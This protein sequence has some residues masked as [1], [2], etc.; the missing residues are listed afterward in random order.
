LSLYFLEQGLTSRRV[1][2]KKGIIARS[3]D[4]ISLDAVET[5]QIE[6]SVF[7]RL[8]GYAS[9]HITGRGDYHMVFDKLGDPMAVKREIEQEAYNRGSSDE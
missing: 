8:F 9:V 4:E 1:I 6:Q 2:W 5:V 3:T 7:G